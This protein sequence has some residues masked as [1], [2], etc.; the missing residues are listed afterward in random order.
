VYF[1]SIF[2]RKEQYLSRLNIVDETDRLIC[3]PIGKAGSPSHRARE[4]SLKVRRRPFGCG[5]FHIFHMMG[6]GVEMD[7]SFVN[8]ISLK[9]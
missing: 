9:M 8:I 6:V 7:W 1:V 3:F 2:H 4:E 5:G